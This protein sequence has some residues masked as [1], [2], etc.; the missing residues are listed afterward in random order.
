MSAWTGL[1]GCLQTGVELC[2]PAIPV[3]GGRQVLTLP[4]SLLESPVGLAAGAAG[5]VTSRL[6]SHPLVRT[7]ARAESYPRRQPAMQ[8]RPSWQPRKGVARSSPAHLGSVLTAIA[9]E[10][11][12]EPSQDARRRNSSAPAAA[13]WEGPT[14]SGASAGRRKRMRA[15]QRRPGAPATVPTRMPV[16]ADQPKALRG[17]AERRAVACPFPSG[18]FGGSGTLQASAFSGRRGLA[19][20]DGSRSLSP[21]VHLS[22]LVRLTARVVVV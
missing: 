8:P 3:P 14:T 16:P 10:R 17:W 1:I 5:W 18:G 22:A 21:T 2:S 13:A 15:M 9:A 11:A 4:V 19:G 7:P 20:H 6:Y 12:V